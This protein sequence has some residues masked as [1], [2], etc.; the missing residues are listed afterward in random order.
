[1]M[2][3]GIIEQVKSDGVKHSAETRFLCHN[4]IAPILPPVR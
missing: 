2:A 1:M 4:R 3:R